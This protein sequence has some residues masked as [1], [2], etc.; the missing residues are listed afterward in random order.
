MQNKPFYN[1]EKHCTAVI[2]VHCKYTMYELQLNIV[3][4]FSL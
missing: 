4:D 3:S 2:H 1:T